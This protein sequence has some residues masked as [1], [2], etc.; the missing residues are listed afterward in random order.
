M[1]ELNL[2]MNPDD[3]DGYLLL[4]QIEL[5]AGDKAAARANVDK[6]LELDPENRHAQR[7]L[8]QLAP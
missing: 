5:T 3:A 4:A 1:A 6:A 2:E 8:Q 7:L